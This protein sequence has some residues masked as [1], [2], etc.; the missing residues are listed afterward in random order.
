MARGVLHGVREEA[1]IRMRIRNA[2]RLSQYVK[3]MS[4]R[5]DHGEWFG[6]QHRVVYKRER[7]FPHDGK[8]GGGTNIIY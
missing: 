3:E 1:V 6:G 8:K 5:F 7:R 2:A 4:P